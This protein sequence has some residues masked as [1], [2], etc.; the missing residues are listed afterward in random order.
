MEQTVQV[1][2]TVEVQQTVQV[3]QQH[4][5]RHRPPHKYQ[6]AS[7]KEMVEHFKKRMRERYNN[8]ENTVN[9]YSRVLEDFFKLEESWDPEF[10]AFRWWIW[11]E[12]GYVG[13]RHVRDYT[14]ALL[15]GKGEKTGER[16]LTV[17]T[18][19]H[20]WI[21]EALT[22]AQTDPLALHRQRASGPEEARAAIR[23]AG[24]KNPGQGRK[25][26]RDAV[27]KHVD[28]SVIKEVL[29]VAL[30]NPLHEETMAKFAAG[31]WTHAGCALG[32]KTVQDAQ[33]FLAMSIFLRQFGPRL[34]VVQNITVGGLQ[35]AEA[36]LVVCPYCKSRVVY[37]THKKRCRE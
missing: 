8:S 32:I 25:E 4:Q 18:H 29:R 33:N 6:G 17:Y 13:I 36:A 5:Q 27:E 15:R 20:T 9:M 30:R 24:T 11:R 26:A 12:E 31:E 22:E 35:E 10:K 21:G 34:E 28:P 23:R 16:I 1:Q 19:L 37:E 7:N 2:Q 14:E 3:L